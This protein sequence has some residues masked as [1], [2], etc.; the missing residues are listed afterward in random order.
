MSAPD[1]QPQPVSGHSVEPIK[2]LS[3]V[4]RSCAR[5]YAQPAAARPVYVQCSSP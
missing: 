1:F 3:H 2:A 5:L 4:G